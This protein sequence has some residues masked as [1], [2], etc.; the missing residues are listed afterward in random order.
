M[1][2]SSVTFATT[3]MA[4]KQN[5]CRFTRFQEILSWLLTPVDGLGAANGIQIHVVFVDIRPR[6]GSDVCRREKGLF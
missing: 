5:R 3:A 2:C 6:E 4:G 1:R